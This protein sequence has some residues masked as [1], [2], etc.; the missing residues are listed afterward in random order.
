M[1]EMNMMVKRKTLFITFIASIYF[2]LKSKWT[3]EKPNLNIF[4]FANI[5][6]IE[7]LPDEKMDGEMIHNY[8][9][10]R[11]KSRFNWKLKASDLCAI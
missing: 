2:E 4:L 10:F 1:R 8:T 3:S 6:F 5:S 7:Q 11:I 9:L